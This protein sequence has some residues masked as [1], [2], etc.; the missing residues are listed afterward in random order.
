MMP[1]STPQ[2]GPD[3]PLHGLSPQPAAVRAAAWLA[4]WGVTLAL[5][6][7]LLVATALGRVLIWRDRGHGGRVALTGMFV[8]DAWVNAHVRPLALNP[9]VERIWIVTDRPMLALPKTEYVCAPGWL[10]R[11]VGSVLAR[12]I[13]CLMTTLRARPN[14][15]GGF[16]LTLNGMVAL[17]CARLVRARGLYYC[18]GGWNEIWGGGARSENRLFAR[19]GADSPGLERQL[20]A[21]A[22]RADLTLTMGTKARD[23]LRANGVRGPIEV[24]AGGIDR[25]QYALG[26]PFAE[27]DFDVIFVGRLVPIKRADVLL[28]ALARARR[29]RLTLRAVI[30]GDGPLRGELEQAARELGVSDCLE[31]AGQRSDVAEWLRRARVFVLC[32]DSEGLPL[33]AME[34]MMSGLPAVVSDVGDLRDLVQDGVNGWLVPRRDPSA[35]AARILNALRSEE[36]WTRLSQA[37]RQAGLRY[38]TEAMVARW[39]PILLR[40]SWAPGGVAPAELK[41]ET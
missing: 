38:S 26:P 9:H 40:E 29:D 33:S 10:R 37:A 15:V 28:A 24:V 31:F 1:A 36:Q 23:Y 22:R 19:L 17:V 41:P 16:H 34:A 27:R 30:V 6:L 25:A 39:D 12:A 18:V 7:A 21:F 3:S 13:W 20:F 35:F 8:S 14:I 2:L 11:V 4:C 32:S 5:R